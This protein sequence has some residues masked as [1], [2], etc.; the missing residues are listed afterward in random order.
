MSFSGKFGK[1]SPEELTG[2][3]AILT[4]FNEK[5]KC[6]TEMYTEE[7]GYLG[8]Y[9]YHLATNQMYPQKREFSDLLCHDNVVTQEPSHIPII[10]QNYMANVK[11][12]GNYYEHAVSHE[13]GTRLLENLSWNGGISYE[14]KFNLYQS[15][16]DVAFEYFG[17]MDENDLFSGFGIIT[18][19]QAQ[20]CFKGK[21][22]VN[23]QYHLLQGFCQSCNNVRLSI[24]LETLH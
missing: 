2:K 14:C 18:F 13:N 1:S 4:E 19:P 16:E 3:L 23:M 21:C 17:K 7:V 9:Q 24:E 15:E 8:T 6:H 5:S 12:A 22:E 10:I 11:F 20:T